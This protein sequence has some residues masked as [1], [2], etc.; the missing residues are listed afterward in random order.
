MRV[1][2]LAALSFAAAGPLR[3]QVESPMKQP[4]GSTPLAT[5]LAKLLLSD[6]QSELVS[7]FVRVPVGSPA[8]SQ[9]VADAIAAHMAKYLPV[10]TIVAVTARLYAEQFNDVDL[11]SMISFFES[12][13]G[14]KFLGARVS[15]ARASQ[16]IFLP[17][18]MAH[19]NELQQAIL[20]ALQSPQ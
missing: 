18:L 16:A 8:Y 2:I 19:Q 6:A 1:F 5:K 9:K 7:P 11:G 12:P 13:T 14:Q 10:D 20:A 4:G 15:V 3:A 17:R